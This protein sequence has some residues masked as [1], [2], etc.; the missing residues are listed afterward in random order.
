MKMFNLMSG[1]L[2]EFTHVNMYILLMHTYTEREK[3]RETDRPTD[4]QADQLRDVAQ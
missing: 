3:E 2:H 1:S 4:R